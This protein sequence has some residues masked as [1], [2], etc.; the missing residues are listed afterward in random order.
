MLRVRNGSL[1]SVGGAERG[2]KHENDVNAG[3][4]PLN[5]LSKP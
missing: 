3:V 1:G 4:T 2:D 5:P